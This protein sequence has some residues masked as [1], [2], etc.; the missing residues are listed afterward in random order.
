MAET[1]LAAR[2]IEV[3]GLPHTC[4]AGALAREKSP[5][6]GDPTLE[7]DLSGMFIRH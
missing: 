6:A 2:C 4:G 7:T 5:S 1:W 3:E